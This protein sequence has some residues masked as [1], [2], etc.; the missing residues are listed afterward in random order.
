MYKLCRLSLKCV[1]AVILMAHATVQATT[2]T[3]VGSYNVSDG[4]YWA[5]N[6]PVY[7]AQE[8]AAL[9][10]GGRP[11]DYAIS[12]NSNT[13]D[14]STITNTGWYSRWG[15]G[16]TTF[17]QSFKRD[18]APAGYRTPGGTDTAISA[19]VQDHC[20]IPDLNHF[21]AGFPF[22]NHVTQTKYFSSLII[23]VSLGLNQ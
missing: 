1:Y 3:Y 6:P 23:A 16:C 8:A 10:F 14:P 11:G 12:V 21:P 18:D 4:D 5:D 9:V 22:T 19:Y 20:G 17:S 13:T 7:T 15:A 2:Y